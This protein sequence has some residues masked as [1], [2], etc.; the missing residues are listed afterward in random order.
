MDQ[1][2]RVLLIIGWIMIT[3]VTLCLTI[4]FG[5]SWVL[6]GIVYKPI[7]WVWDYIDKKRY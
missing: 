6:S 2:I 4:I 3:F 1:V 7:E 5:I